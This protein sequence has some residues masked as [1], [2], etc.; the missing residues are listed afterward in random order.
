[1]QR[2]STT[3]VI[4]LFLNYKNISAYISAWN[5]LTM[6]NVYKESTAIYIIANW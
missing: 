6:I 5:V 4:D 3:L 2:Y 1:M